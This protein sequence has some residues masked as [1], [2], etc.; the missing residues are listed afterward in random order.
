[1]AVKPFSWL[2]SA[3]VFS[4]RSKDGLPQDNPETS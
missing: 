2:E 1:M 4:Q 3:R